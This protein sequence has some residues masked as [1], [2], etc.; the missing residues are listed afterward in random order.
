MN[1][2]A[3]PRTTLRFVFGT[4]S[5]LLVLS[6]CGEIPSGG[7]VTDLPQPAAEAIVQDASRY[8]GDPMEQ[9]AREEYWR[10]H[11]QGALRLH[12]SWEQRLIEQHEQDL[13]NAPPAYEGDPWERRLRE[14]HG[15]R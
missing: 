13:R 5:S 11:Q 14:Q 6:A 4:L 12:D 1:T 8:I 15:S 9:R 7:V 10:R 3:R 2:T